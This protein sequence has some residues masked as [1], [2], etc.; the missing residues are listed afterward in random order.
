[1]R[2]LTPPFEWP[3]A[4]PRRWLLVVCAS[5]YA[6]ALPGAGASGIGQPTQP[7]AWQ[8]LSLERDCFGCP[9]GQRLLLRRDGS[10]VAT[11]LGNARRGTQDESR[12]GQVTPAEFQAL[13]RL[14][15]QRGFMSMPEAYQLGDTQ[16]GAW[17]TLQ[18]AYTG[19][20]G[21]LTKAVFARDE[22]A[23]AELRDL[24]SAVE[25]LQARAGLKP[26]PK[27]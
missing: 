7:R 17:T 25:A 14:L 19:P 10:V 6:C 9:S 27:Q 18:V 11:Q 5:L 26:L 15:E 22:A 2:P 24:W 20:A 1:M 16:D 12:Q 21:E 23:P 3:F 8:W 4:P 13:M